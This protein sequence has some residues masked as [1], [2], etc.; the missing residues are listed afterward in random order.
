MVHKKRTHKLED[1]KRKK[2][3]TCGLNS[4]GPFGGWKWSGITG[5]HKEGRSL[6][7]ALL[8]RLTSRVSVKTNQTTTATTATQWKSA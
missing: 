1:E 2:N 8:A 4:V 7:V 3:E 5:L 6:N